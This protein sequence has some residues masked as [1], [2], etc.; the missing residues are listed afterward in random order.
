MIMLTK[1]QNLLETIRGGQPDR[2]VNQYEFLHILMNDPYNLTDPFPEY[3]QKN[4]KN[5]WGVTL[6][7]PEG[8]PGAFP[9]HDDK[10]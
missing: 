10:H 5:A 1:K 8:T 2:F 9:V 4:V 6:S 7:W 3:G